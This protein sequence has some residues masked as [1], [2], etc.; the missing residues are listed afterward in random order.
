[1]TPADAE[2]PLTPDEFRDII[3]TF[4]SGVT[5]ITTRDAGEPLGTTANALSSLSLEPPMLLI[6]MNKESA[7]GVIPR[8]HWRSTSHAR[9]ATSSALSSTRTA[10]WACHCSPTPSRISNARSPRR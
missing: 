8:A 3:G 1:M 2:R 6:C 9:G 5:V 4:A 10:C 7:T